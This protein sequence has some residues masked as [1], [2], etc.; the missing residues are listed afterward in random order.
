MDDDDGENVGRRRSRSFIVEDDDEDIDGSLD[1][2]LDD[3][4]PPFVG[5]AR[6][7]SFVVSADDEED[8]AD[9]FGGGGRNR[10]TSFAISANDGDPEQ[11]TFGRSR[12]T[13]FAVDQGGGAGSADDMIRRAANLSKISMKGSVALGGV[14]YC[15]TPSASTAKAVIVPEKTG[16]LDTRMLG[17]LAKGLEADKVSPKMMTEEELEEMQLAREEAAKLEE[18]GK[19]VWP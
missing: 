3:D 6:G 1:A 2:D 10:G 16:A 12:G 4:D 19:T 9:D 13:S 17:A 7:T 14:D 11:Q 5:R 15:P 18:V 8:N